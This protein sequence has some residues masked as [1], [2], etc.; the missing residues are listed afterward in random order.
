M[1]FATADGGRPSSFNNLQAELAILEARLHIVKSIKKN[2]MCTEREDAQQIALVATEKNIEFIKQ[3]IRKSGFRWI[4]YSGYISLWDRLYNADE[5]MIYLLPL[6]TAIEDAENDELRLQDSDI[7][8]REKLLNILNV[9][10]GTLRSLLEHGHSQQSMTQASPVLVNGAI[11]SRILSVSTQPIPQKPVFKRIRHII[12][13][14]VGQVIWVFP[15]NPSTTNNGQASQQTE[16]QARADIRKI[17]YTIHKFKSTRLK[18]LVRRRIQLMATVEI[19]G[20][21]TFLLVILAILGG[22]LPG[23]MKQMII[24]YF[25]GAIVGL[26]GRLYNEA[27]TTDS[28][29]DDYGLTMARILVTPI[30]SGLAALLGVFLTVLLSITLVTPVHQSLTATTQQIFPQINTLYDYNLYPQNLVFAAIF[31]FLPNL[32]INMLQ[33]KSEDVK[34][35]IKSNSA[36]EQAKGGDSSS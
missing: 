9:A 1:S 35:Q 15:Q 16:E 2:A 34:S 26:F 29:V 19:T 3:E 22:V 33:Q 11:N 21:F 30:L 14:I 17:R 31:G 6:P 13:T 24:F 10:I 32:V 36:A 27:N 20:L 28:N 18:G 8:D 23:Q 4:S 7:S 12:R 25:L 5:T